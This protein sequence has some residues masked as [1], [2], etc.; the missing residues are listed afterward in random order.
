MAEEKEPHNIEEEESSFDFFLKFLNKQRQEE[1]KDNF[2]QEPQ[3]NVENNKKTLLN[4]FYS[5]FDSINHIMDAILMDRKKAKWFSLFMATML[6]IF[7]SGANSISNSS[8]TGRVVSDVPI[9]IINLDENYVVT[10]MQETANLMLVGNAFS[11]QTTM[12]KKDYRLYADLSGFSE[13]VYSVDLKL[14]GISKNIT[15]S[16]V[17]NKIDVVISP[18]ETRV[19][20]LG[21]RYINE[22]KK[23]EKFVLETP[24]LSKSEVTVTGGKNVLDMI[25]SVEASIDV[26][27]I[28]G[29]FNQKATIKAYDASG[30]ELDV[31]IEPNTVDVSVNVTSFSKTVPIQIGAIGNIKSSLA[32]ASFVSSEASVT[33]YGEEN[34][35][36]QINS[37]K[38]NID[39]SDI[40]ESTT[41]HGVNIDYPENVRG[42]ISSINV[43]VV[44]E[45]RSTK[46]I[47][48]IPISVENSGNRQ[49]E[50]LNNSSYATVEVTGATSKVSSF[51][52][53]SIL[54]S[55]DLSN[56][57]A[58]EHS[59]SVSVKSQDSLISIKLISKSEVMVKI[60]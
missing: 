4:L 26:K 24:V 20:A 59:V 55:I 40:T 15:A 58:G 18:K 25:K 13:G 32:I 45:K 23:D 9:E 7:T 22:D 35:L 48:N 46:V 37:V 54:A 47:N 38:A 36:K 17:P 2:K 39:V 29:P 16:A 50:F 60:E 14:E 3:N 31:E 19:F 11:V 53:A 57:D 30:K 10:N 51:D 52:T 43:D 6:F 49:V 12:I 33:L 42:S 56:L 34:V 5:L 41:I 27:G 44:V 21:Y 8:S 28:E 1:I